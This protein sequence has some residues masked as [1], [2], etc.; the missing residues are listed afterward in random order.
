MTIKFQRKTN[1]TREAKVSIKALNAFAKAVEIQ[2]L[3][4]QGYT[5]VPYKYETDFQGFLTNK[6]WLYRANCENRTLWIHA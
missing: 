6:V 2:K 1:G 3:E 4:R 5:V